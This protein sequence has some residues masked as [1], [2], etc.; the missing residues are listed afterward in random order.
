MPERQHHG[1]MMPRRGRHRDGELEERQVLTTT[2]VQ[3][4]EAAL[5]QGFLHPRQLCC[6]HKSS[7]RESTDVRR[8]NLNLEPCRDFVQCHGGH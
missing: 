2:T 5:Q 7:V 8:Q 1:E 4:G 3:A 6:L